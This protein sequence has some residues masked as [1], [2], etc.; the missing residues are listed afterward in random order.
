MF[1]IFHLQ[2]Q[3]SNH[4]VRMANLFYFRKKEETH[5]PS[6]LFSVKYSKVLA[7]QWV[8]LGNWIRSPWV[9]IMY[10]I[11]SYICS[12]R[13]EIC[14]VLPARAVVF[15]R[16]SHAQNA[17][18]QGLSVLHTFLIQISHNGNKTLN[19]LEFCSRRFSCSWILLSHFNEK[20]FRNFW[21]IHTE[22]TD[23]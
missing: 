23:A 5:S 6:G 12:V 1:I 15:E 20:P 10:E 4:C 2:S 19:A 14:A 8:K 11:R 16:R 7:L 9:C 22:A 17:R 13:T 18:T 3:N 21:T